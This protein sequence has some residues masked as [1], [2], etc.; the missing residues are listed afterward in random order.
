M[1]DADPYSWH[2]WDQYK[3]CRHC[4]GWGL[5]PCSQTILVEAGVTI[6]IALDCLHHKPI[7][8]NLLQL[9]G[10]R[11]VYWYLIIWVEGTEHLFGHTD[12]P[13]WNYLKN[14]K[15]MST[16]RLQTERSHQAYKTHNDKNDN[17]SSGRQ[18]RPQSGAHQE[19]LH[20]PLAY[21]HSKN[22]CVNR[23]KCRSVKHSTM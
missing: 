9:V 1:A 10:E 13:S 15:L 17:L 11:Q 5:P 7:W 3:S 20:N 2:S 16:S 6:L 23:S 4:L 21:I 18:R 22:S 12:V 19:A 14:V 8:A